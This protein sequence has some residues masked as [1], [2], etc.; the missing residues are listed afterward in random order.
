MKLKLENRYV[1]LLVPFLQGMRLK[2]AQSRARSKLLNLAIEAYGSLH[3]SEL[4]LLREFAVLGEDGEP[5]M[6]EDGGFTLKDGRAREY[7]AERGR[8]FSEVAEIEGGTY[9]SHLAAM[10]EVLLGYDGEM[11]G[12][13]AALYDA[14]MDA[15]EEVGT[16]AGE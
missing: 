2:G 5:V 3:E 8:L 15:F 6:D 9:A 10:R 7:L 4:E 11:S 14:L 12:D 16:D 13:D 1:A